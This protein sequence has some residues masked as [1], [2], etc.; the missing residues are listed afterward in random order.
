[1]KTKPLSYV[2]ENN[3]EVRGSAAFE[4]FVKRS[5]YDYQKVLDL[6]EKDESDSFFVINLD[7]T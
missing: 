7:E 4:H 5:G 2:D 3:K 6:I 1:M